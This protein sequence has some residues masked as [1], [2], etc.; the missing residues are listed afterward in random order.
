M[1]II[2]FMKLV[3]E[4][5]NNCGLKCFGPNYYIFIHKGLKKATVNNT[6]YINMDNIAYVLVVCAYNW[7]N[8]GYINNSLT[9][10]VMV[11]GMFNP[12]DAIPFGEWDFKG[13]EFT[14]FPGQ[15]YSKWKPY[16]KLALRADPSINNFEPGSADE[17]SK[18]PEWEW[19][20][21]VNHDFQT[22]LDDINKFAEANKDIC[23]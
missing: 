8:M 3:G 17:P 11:D 21:D 22:L 14:T 23:L 12:V 16:P 1:N 10:L 13:L 5:R 9:Q 15:W 20:G 6:G 2:D 19:H 18:F 7:E 4:I